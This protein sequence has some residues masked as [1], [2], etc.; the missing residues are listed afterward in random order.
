MLLDILSLLFRYTGTIKLPRIE[1]AFINGVIDNLVN[2][3][4]LKFYR[5]PSSEQ[6]ANS[7][8]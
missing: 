2:S 5:N 8:K 6:Y 1:N 4:T 3:M 7:G